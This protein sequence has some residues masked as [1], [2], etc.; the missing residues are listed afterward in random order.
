[1]WR[2]FVQAMDPQGENNAI[3]L[4][5]LTHSASQ[6]EITRTYKRMA[7]QWHPDRHKDPEEK[8]AAQETFI[9]IQQAYE[10]LSRIKNQRAK[11]NRRERDNP[12]HFQSKHEDL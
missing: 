8:K 12:N 5:N 6:D 10:L 3:K 2:E 11:R 7:R 4:L 1:M 9:Q